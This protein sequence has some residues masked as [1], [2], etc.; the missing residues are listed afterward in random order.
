MDDYLIMVDVTKSG[1]WDDIK[2]IDFIVSATDPEDAYTKGTKKAKNFLSN[3][4]KDFYVWEI[5]EEDVITDN[6]N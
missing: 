2:V 6:I 1:N 5:T 4:Y 3:G